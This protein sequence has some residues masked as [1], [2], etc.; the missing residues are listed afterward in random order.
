MSARSRDRRQRVGEV[1][2]EPRVVECVPRFVQEGLVVVEPA[3]RARDQMHHRGRVGRD[4]A[5]ARALLRPVIQVELDAAVR[6]QVEA[7]GGERLQADG[8][9]AILGVALCEGRH[10]P[11]VRDL[12]RGRLGVALHAEHA[13]EPLL[14]KRRP[15]ALLEAHRSLQRLREGVEVDVLARG[16]RPTASG[17]PESSASRSSPFCISL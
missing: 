7:Q 5:G 14:A 13:V 10:A 6:G 8:H 2:V 17:S 1:G 12:V 3:L 15:R 4:H 16:F 9:A 11:Q